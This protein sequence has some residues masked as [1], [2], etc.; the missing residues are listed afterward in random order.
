MHLYP[1]F[2]VKNWS[3][4]PRPIPKT[5]SHAHSLSAV[6]LITHACIMPVGK[7]RGASD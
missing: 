7:R 5:L 4:G 6:D 3:S 2:Q 1:H